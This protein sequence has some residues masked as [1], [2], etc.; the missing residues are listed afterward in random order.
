MSRNT[1]SRITQQKFTKAHTFRSIFLAHRMRNL[2]HTYQ[3]IHSKRIL[4]LKS[5]LDP[6][7]IL[8]LRLTRPRSTCETPWLM[9][10]FDFCITFYATNKYWNKISLVHLYWPN[11]RN[12]KHKNIFCRKKADILALVHSF[13]VSIRRHRNKAILWYSGYVF[14]K[15]FYFKMILS[16][17]NLFRL[18]FIWRKTIR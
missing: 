14:F 17:S 5:V 4:S 12:S 13:H 1:N 6:T 9:Q 8:P 3:R 16:V 10:H 7:R 15:T 2:K 18:L 11:G